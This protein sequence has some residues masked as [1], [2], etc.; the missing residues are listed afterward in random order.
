VEACARGEDRQI[1]SWISVKATLCLLPVQEDSTIR[2]TGTC[3]I[4]GWAATLGAETINWTAT[5]IIAQ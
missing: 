5:N 4:A 3:E 2:G 1:G